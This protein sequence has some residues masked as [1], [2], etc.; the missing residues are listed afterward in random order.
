MKPRCPWGFRKAQAVAMQP[1]D[2]L[3][4]P[5][6]D[7]Y[8]LHKVACRLGIPVSLRRFTTGR[9]SPVWVTAKE[10]GAS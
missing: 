10:G 8:S 7:A 9:Q 4:L 1:G 6:R 5:R 3:L 2:S